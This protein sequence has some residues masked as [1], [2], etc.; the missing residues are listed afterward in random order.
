MKK[1][2][3]IP[4][5]KTILLNGKAVVKVKSNLIKQKTKI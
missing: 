1:R 5:V 3:K 2:K 4:L